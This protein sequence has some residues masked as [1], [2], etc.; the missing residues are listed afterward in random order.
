MSRTCL[1]ILGLMAVAGMGFAGG[2]EVTWTKNFDQA[3]LQAQKTG[4]AVCVY[5]KFTAKGGGC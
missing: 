4:K 1:A 5:T 3:L 2:D